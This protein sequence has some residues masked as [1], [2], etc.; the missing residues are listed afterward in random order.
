[1]T[2]KKLLGAA[3]IGT[4]LLAVVLISLSY[5][6][7]SSQQ[8]YQ[9]SVGHLEEI[10]TQINS[11]FRSAITG[12]WRLLRSWRNYI[13]YAS[14]EQPE[15]LAAF[16]QE[17]KSAWHFTSF[18]FLA[19]DGSYITDLGGVGKLELEKN[20]DEQTGEYEEIVM[21]E[22]PAEPAGR[23]FSPFPSV[24]DSIGT[25]ITLPSASVSTATT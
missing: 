12:S 2:R 5:S 16:I 9:E 22:D 3:A 19:R 8:I 17:E 7:F 1:M 24:R 11:A 14:E 15:E 13:S 18:Y 25:S 20:L 6:R 23:P 21:T 4:V 10:Y